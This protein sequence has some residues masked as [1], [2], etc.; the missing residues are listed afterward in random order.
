MSATQISFEP[1]FYIV[2]GTVERDAPCYVQR[3]ADND[4]YDGLQ[5]GKFC[6][7][8]TSRQ[9][10]KSSL[11][12][13]TAARLR[14]EGVGIAVLDLTAI[15][16]N[17]S[18]E[19]WYDGLLTQIA[20][21]LDLDDE[22][23]EFWAAHP[24]LGPL[25]RWMQAIRQVVL[26]RYV[27]RV[28]IF[29]DE[30][31][32]VRSLP[33]STDEFFAGIREF[34]NRRTEDT[35]LERLTFCLLG[36]ATPSDLIR[37]TR[38]TPFNIGRRIELSDFTEAEAAPL[39]QGLGREESV[40]KELLKR[41]LHW[42]GGHPYLTQR[43]CQAV[44][45]DVSVCDAKGVDR[46]CEELFLS[47]R[48][49]ER[50]DNLL[51][52]RER[53]LR[54]EADLASLLDLYAHVRGGK[55]V[56][57]EVTNPL[58]GVLR[59]SGITRVEGSYL[60]VRN[61]IY[62]RVFDREW[63]RANMPDA[64]VRRQ[65]AAYRRGLVRAAVV[66]TVIVAIVISLAWTAMKQRN[67]AQQQERANSQLLYAARMN[68]AGQDWETGNVG[69]MTEYLNAYLPQPGQTDIRGFEWHY[70]WRISHSSL[71]TLQPGSQV[72]AVTF[73]PDGKTLAFA[74]RRGMLKLW[75]AATGQELVAF[76]GHTDDVWGVAF[77]PDGKR[78]ASGSADR[79]V[80]LWDVETGQEL[81]VIRGHTN[82]VQAIAFSPD[83]KLLASGGM[84]QTVKLWEVITR[85]EL[86]T[87]KGFQAYRNAPTP[88]VYPG[89]VIYSGV[90]VFSP[91]GKQLATSSIGGLVKLWNVATGQAV[92][93]FKGNTQLTC[94]AAFSP[95]WKKLAL[96]GI[97]HLVKLWD[98]ATGQELLTLKG[99]NY[100]ISSVAFSP[101]G[102]KL[103]SGSPDGTSKLWD[104][105]T[106]QELFTF[107]GH[108][109]QVWS[110]AY[111]PDGQKIATGSQDQT[112]KLW[113]VA[114]EPEKVMLNDH[115]SIYGK[116][117]F[118]FSPD[119][120]LAVGLQ[121][122]GILLRDMA[123]GSE[124]VAFK[125]PGHAAYLI[126]FSPD[127]KRAIISD[128]DLRGTIKRKLV[129]I[130]TGRELAVV[131]SG[132]GVL[133]A[134]I[135]RDFRWLAMGY[136]DGAVRLWETATGKEVL[137][138]KVHPQGVYALIFSPNSKW[139]ATASADHMIKLWEVS[140]GKELRQI[141]GHINDIIDLAFSPDG[142]SL[143]SAGLDRT[144][145]LWDTATGREMA[146]L[147]GHTNTVRTVAFSPDGRRLVSGSSDQTVKLWDV[148]TGQ[149]LLTLKGHT[150]EVK[151]VAF[152]P[153]G[154]WLASVADDH[155][156]ILWRAAIEQE[157]TASL[158]Q[159]KKEQANQIT[160]TAPSSI[161]VI[162]TVSLSLDGRRMVTGDST[163]TLK[164]WEPGRELARSH[165]QT[166]GLNASAFSPD[167]KMVAS[168]GD[169][170]AIR[171][172]DVATWREVATLRGHVGL[173]QF[174]AFSPDGKLLA[175]GSDDQTVRLW[176][177]AT[178]R[179]L[180]TLKHTSIVQ[181]VAFSSDSKK[182]VSGSLNNTIK[183]WDAATAQELA[184]LTGHTNVVRSVAFSPDGKLI[185]SGSQDQ[186]IKLWDATTMKEVVT[187][188][189]HAGP[190]FA[191][192]FSPDGQ[193][194]A[195]AGNDYTIK[196]W[197]VATRRE[198]SVLKGLTGQ[199]LR[200]VF[201]P[202]G[203]TLAAGEDTPSLQLWDVATRKLLTTEP[204]DKLRQ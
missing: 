185:A 12:V 175:S 155:R 21:Q 171:L 8:L 67:R 17:L 51:F 85:R 128:N 154:Q 197:D 124:R 62:E 116:H 6:Y 46:L 33:F 114:T 108:I 35:E 41:V 203:K 190:V 130:A 202:D 169:D 113:G 95:D 92:H 39:V 106:G 22:L 150:N 159:L 19:Q 52:V 14:E 78:L 134:G 174:L 204:S 127:G 133:T 32:A 37:D 28:V 16:Q 181:C 138:L 66:A 43:L 76:N 188:K 53:I 26:P 104:A 157:A 18:A 166:A 10:G 115:G 101:D 89:A 178:R 168:G 58:V 9:M 61:H 158:E 44:A 187:L 142:R 103:V 34:Y 30:I 173:L 83:G 112:I 47:H 5:Q 91:D 170:W 99:H 193:K 164:L 160:S 151:Q 192:A 107:K 86:L 55:R 125:E 137:T 82:W 111:S 149:E 143:A 163:G 176:E 73:S 165:G 48:A 29:V 118:S 139:L 161:T 199:V 71:M 132:S 60:R 70:L 90:L 136:R 20:Q 54:S 182:I 189:G 121:D 105:S 152:S 88:I 56:A 100:G 3:R 141:K 81:A 156:M 65:R 148:V 59:L 172:W 186:T 119:G 87:L 196:L 167:G 117:P 96:G 131:W 198:L 195:S 147:N 42:T 126:G 200:L 77:S 75:D 162:D 63:V 135:S 15:G 38:T 102:Q 201:S 68:L 50:D 74:G 79:T 93:A 64:E 120:T 80:R 109:G 23:E 13:R 194:L 177:V 145:K 140:T 123:T 49:Q 25:Q 4:L 144:V 24:K 153:D 122:G 94:S 180:A 183:L 27:S 69:R 31:D 97:D 84:D 11:M 57:D 40:G 1:S 7:V 72:L 179:E 98:V 110:V 129:E 45:E 184:T 191:V 36:V 2:G 146:T